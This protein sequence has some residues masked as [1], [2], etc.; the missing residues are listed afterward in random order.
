MSPAIVQGASDADLVAELFRRRPTDDLSPDATPKPRP[1]LDA[2]RNLLTSLV[3]QLGPVITPLILQLLQKLLAG[4]GTSSNAVS[5]EAAHES[6]I[7]HELLNRHSVHSMSSSVDA[8]ERPLLDAI[9]QFLVGIVDQIGPSLAPFL[10]G[11]LQK[12]LSQATTQPKANA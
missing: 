4:A 12:L 11:L 7:V 10:I 6:E 3:G 2:I 9:R 1:V 5:L 8:A